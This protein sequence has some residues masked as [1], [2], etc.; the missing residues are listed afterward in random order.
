M[1]EA[2]GHNRGRVDP[3]W[4]WAD[5]SN[6]ASC[7]E[8][9]VASEPVMS[10]DVHSKLPTSQLLF[11]DIF[12]SSG[13]YGFALLAQR[14]V[15]FILLPVYTRFLTPS[16]YG[17][18]ELL[19][20]VMYV[21][22]I[23]FGGAY[24]SAL[25][26][27][28]FLY[29][30]TRWRSTVTSTCILGSTL[31]GLSGS[32][33]GWVLSIPLCSHLLHEPSFVPYCRIFFAAMAAD[34]LL[35]SLLLWLRVVN[36]PRVYVTAS[37]VRLCLTVACTLPLLVVF[38]LGIT[39]VLVSNL[40]ATSLTA[41]LFT[42]YSAPQV[43]FHF[44]PN[45]FLRMLRFSI[46]LSMTSLA[47]LFIHFGDRFF[48]QHYRN[49]TDVGLYGLAYKIGMLISLIYSTFHAYWSAQVFD[50]LR[51]ADGEF[52]FSRVFTYLML[53][54]SWSAVGLIV[55]SKP[56]LR[57]LTTP[58][59]YSAAALVPVI[60]FAYWIRAIGDF[61]RYLFLV[62]NR[63]VFDTICNILG[64]VVCLAGYFIFIPAFG[65]QGAAIATLVTFATISAVAVVWTRKLRPLPVEARRLAKIVIT[66]AALIAAFFLLPCPEGI[67][68]GLVWAAILIATYPLVLI[69][70]NFPTP[71]EYSR[72]R[73]VMRCLAL[74]GTRW[75][76]GRGVK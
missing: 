62:E 4:G 32:A 67:L 6:C 10:S 56:A 18:I 52:V 16:D 61:F 7:S 5:S 72:V 75:L 22:S 38:H 26:Y 9:L 43:G 70:L 57:I 49:L 40:I 15:G 11:L 33:L 2:G 23:L 51:R 28:Y 68:P 17:V 29:D 48:L 71:G 42:I 3:A 14:L 47:L 41:I 34:F 76:L 55:L 8:I 13:L 50:I 30:S 53:I 58:A 25:G 37:I 31:L 19:T 46:P 65:S 1:P 73:I 44:D 36:R 45:V 27:H 39:G 69:L 74:T 60:V 63:P 21:L 12:R 20:Q 54:L 35:E 64:A 66:A 59:F 24:S